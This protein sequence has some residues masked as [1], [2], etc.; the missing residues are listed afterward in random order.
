MFVVVVELVVV[1]YLKGRL[2][3]VVGMVVMV[4]VLVLVCKFLSWLVVFVCLE[5][6]LVEERLV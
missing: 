2:E 1:V 6:A 3:A 5:V 4:M